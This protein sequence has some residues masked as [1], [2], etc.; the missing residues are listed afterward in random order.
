MASSWEELN[1][2]YGAPAQAPAAAGGDAWTELNAKYSAPA[3]S[4]SGNSQTVSADGP[5]AEA[6]AKK[7]VGL[8]DRVRAG[9]AGVNKGFFSD[10]LGMPVDAVQNVIDLGKAGYGT[11]VT[12][13]GRPDLAP[14]INMD[15]SGVV[16]SSD[17]IAKKINQGADLAGVESPISNPNP[18]DPLSR[19]AHT[20][21]RFVG[22]SVV[23]S[24]RV[25]IGARQQAVNTGMAGVSGLASGATAEVAPDYAGLAGMVPSMTART[26]ADVVRMLAQG[27]EAGRQ[28][29]AQR[30]Q[31]FKNAGVDNPSAGMATGN[32]LLQG[33]E[34]LLGVTP[35]SMDIIGNN[36]LAMMLGLQ[37]KADTLRG[38]ISPVYGAA[39]A[40]TGIQRDLKGPFK[41][42]ISNTYGL[43]NDKVEQAI[44]ADTPIMVTN[45]LG[46]AN[47]LSSLVPG[48][49]ATSSLLINPRIAQIAENLRTD[50]FGAPRIDRGSPNIGNPTLNLP[51]EP[52]APQSSNPSLWNQP[53]AQQN[54][55]ANAS[56]WNQPAA[57]N[58]PMP[59]RPVVSA[60]GGNG[61]PNASL[62]NTQKEP[63]IPFSAVKQLRTRIGQEAA[64]SEIMGT[65]QQ[66]EYKQLYG[67]LS[68]DMKA[69][70]AMADLV[71]GTKGTQALERAN[72]YYSHAMARAEAMGPLANRSTPEGA[73]D[74]VAS[75]LKSG[76]TTYGRVRNAVSTDTRQ[77]IVA[78]IVD[79]MGRAT[80][81]QQNAEGSEWSAKT[82]ITNYN[83]IDP[84]ARDALFKRLP[85]GAQY[86][87]DLRDIAK[88]ADMVN[89][90]GQQWANPSGTGANVFARG[91][92]S[93]LTVGAFYHPMMAAGT[94]AT[95]ATGAG[96]ARLLTNPK[97][98][99]WLAEA[100]KVKPEEARAYAQRIM[101]A[102]RQSGD[103]QFQR[104]VTEYL[105]SVQQGSQEGN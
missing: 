32:R 76:P 55:V 96:V 20:G 67:G 29:T 63:G 65:P 59:N 66:G 5:R 97:F 98:V 27:R 87:D 7:E 3:A 99:N 54:T 53:P 74:S 35:G 71:N 102:A 22:G 15:R 9:M 26:G 2:K 49:E 6:A 75:S 73:Y 104:D 58:S 64:S 78:T 48:A 90:G 30:V 82:F 94:A 81:G 10:L 100:P 47:R 34:N 84:A 80:P 36:R 46:T 11:V 42:R 93:A 68:Q 86:A 1:A 77:K 38:N 8:L 18:Q 24:S 39:E 41:E 25:A 62:W 17:W 51:L 79:D 40:G 43:L 45:S 13:A 89:Q 56:L 31:D 12:A 72:Q 33:V 23:P 4:N 19:V 101:M 44:G 92:F 105:W 28:N 16:G 83:K 95:L 37:N 21:G 14:N 85:G 88:A 70:V 52:A 69:G 57:P 50:A 61:A 91:T 103:Q 60:T